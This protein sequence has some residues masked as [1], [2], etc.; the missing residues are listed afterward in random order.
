MN[1]VQLE[2][3]LIFY[4]DIQYTALISFIYIF[5]DKNYVLKLII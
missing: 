4:V 2:T 1:I 3:G 5:Y